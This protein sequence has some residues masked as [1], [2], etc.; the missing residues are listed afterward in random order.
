MKIS[1]LLDYVIAQE[2]LNKKMIKNLVWVAPLPTSQFHVFL[3][4][5]C[6]YISK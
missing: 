3:T 1:N 2:T 4:K 6:I 5:F